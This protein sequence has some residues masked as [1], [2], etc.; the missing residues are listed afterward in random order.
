M[1]MILI[2]VL[3]LDQAKHKLENWLKFLTQKNLDFAYQGIVMPLL[4]DQLNESTLIFKIYI[5]I[6]FAL[7]F[8]LNSHVIIV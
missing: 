1:I 2:Q 6:I 7:Y 4:V 8:D 5:E 3:S